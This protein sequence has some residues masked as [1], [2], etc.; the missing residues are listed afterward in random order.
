MRSTPLAGAI[1]LL[2]FASACG[3]SESGDTSSIADVFP[4]GFNSE[5]IEASSD[6]QRDL[7]ADGDVTFA[8]HQKA[9]LASFACRE[10]R[11]VQWY[12]EPQLRT[13]YR[14]GLFYFAESYMPTGTREE[15]Q[16]INEE[17]DAEY[18]TLVGMAW[19][20]K[21]RPYEEEAM[22]NMWQCMREAGWELSDPPT[23]EEELALTGEQVG[24]DRARCEIEG[25]EKVDVSQLFAE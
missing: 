5:N 17:C 16:R 14:A 4:P 18:Y 22:G 12:T 6:F 8:D 2:V 11:G 24:H 15:H 13:D 1:A 3:G 9:S 23:V 19:A 25:W 20:W 21:I 10:E 7:L